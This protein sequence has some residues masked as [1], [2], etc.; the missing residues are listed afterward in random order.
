M[1]PRDLIYTC[2]RVRAGDEKDSGLDDR[3]DANLLLVCAEYVR[4]TATAAPAKKKKAGKKQQDGLLDYQLFLPVLLVCLVRESK[5]V[6]KAALEC[7]SAIKDSYD[8]I[9]SSSKKPE[10][11]IF[12]HGKFFG[13]DSG[14][15]RS[16]SHFFLLYTQTN[17]CTSKFPWH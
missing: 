2:V 5:S 7:L 13:P 8:M 12:G 10:T 1:R 6:R 14:I 15:C 17:C 11:V 16:S 4:K 9:L 3:V